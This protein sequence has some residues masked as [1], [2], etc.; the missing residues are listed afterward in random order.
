MTDCTNPRCGSE[1][2][3]AAANGLLLCAPCTRR[4]HRQV[5]ELATLYAELSSSLRSGGMGGGD[6]WGRGL[7]LEEK[8][9]EVRTHIV[10]WLRAWAALVPRERGGRVVHG[11]WARGLTAWVPADPLSDDHPYTVATWIRK[12]V[13]WFAASPDWAGEAAATLDA[14][15]A[16]ALDA[17]QLIRTRRFAIDGPSGEPIRCPVRAEGPRDARSATQ[18]HE[19]AAAQGRIRR[20]YELSGAWLLRPTPMCGGKLIGW[21]RDAED[22]NGKPSV[23][24]CENDPAHEWPSTAWHTLGRRLQPND[25]QRAG[26]ILEAR[27]AK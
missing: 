5:G 13:P 22:E 12:N 2:P 26:R 4:M 21:V 14:T 10:V 6:G 20:G 19:R 1:R 15:V 17:R 3:R 24:Q 11:P 8:V 16:E 7:S 18:E 23:I 27:F 25:P 9:L